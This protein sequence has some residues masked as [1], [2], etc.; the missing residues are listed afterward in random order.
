MFSKGNM[1]P[2]VN[3]EDN[4]A[5]KGKGRKVGINA[6]LLFVLHNIPENR[7]ISGARSAGL[8]PA[9]F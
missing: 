2:L 7:G 3:L 6:D 4:L 1:E 9:T 8:E 5:T